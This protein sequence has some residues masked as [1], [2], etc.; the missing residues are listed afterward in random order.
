M[1]SAESC[2]TQ[3]A[4]LTSQ[5]ATTSEPRVLPKVS[6][7]KISAPKISWPKLGGR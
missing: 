2:P 1:L 6:L 5:S 4:S 7:P 3:N